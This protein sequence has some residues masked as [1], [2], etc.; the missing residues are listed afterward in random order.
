[1]VRVGRNRHKNLR[2]P[3]GWA[4]SRS[5]VIYFRPTNAG[6]RAIV[7]AITGGR[8]SLRL[9]ATHDEAAEAFA[10]LIVA[11]RRRQDDAKPGTVAEIAQRGREE[12][13]PRIANPE[14]RA[15]RGRH[16]EALDKAFGTSPYA[17][18]VYDASRN[19]AFLRSLDVQ[20]HL[21]ANAHRPAAA[22]REVM[23]WRILFDEARRR[24]GLTEFN[25]CE[26]VTLHPERPRETLPADV[27]V[28]G[29]VYRQLDPPM[30]FAVAMIRFYGRRKK[31]ILGA[32]L[33]SAQDDGLHLRRAKG[34]RELV[35]V[36]DRRLRRM[37]HR[38]M[39]WRAAKKRDG[40]LQTTMAILNR[41]GRRVTVTGFNSAWRRAMERAGLSGA[42]TFHDL[43]ASRA[44]T[45][46]AEEATEVLAHDDAATTRRIYRRG[47]LRIALSD[48]IP[49]NLRELPKF[50]KEKAP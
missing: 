38:L 45:L 19:P 37:W 33:S 40:K 50:T 7:R 17:P 44:S 11:A 28:F 36:W 34:D 15:W 47:P 9:G 22:N 20:R 30:R 6:D 46:T 10:R 16:L 31:E 23:S 3:V 49:E 25:P 48:G 8:L 4:P 1:M 2:M 5:G 42:F 18:S 39:R 27:D 35:L 26:G 41:R 21:D 29:K 43:R 24:W 14:T 12:W 32:T 13:L